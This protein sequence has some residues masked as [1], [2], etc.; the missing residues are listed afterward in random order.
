MNEHIHRAMVI[1]MNGPRVDRLF[2]TVAV[3]SDSGGISELFRFSKYRPDS[4][5]LLRRIT[6]GTWFSG[7][8]ILKENKPKP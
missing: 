8:Q 3:D 7:L 2:S 1:R 5:L 6:S 4:S